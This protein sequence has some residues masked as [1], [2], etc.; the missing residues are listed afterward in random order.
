M[1]VLFVILLMP[2][3]LMAKSPS[4]GD[5]YKEYQLKNGQSLTN[6]YIRGIGNGKIILDSEQGRQVVPINDFADGVVI[7]ASPAEKKPTPIAANEIII[8]GA[9]GLKL[10]DTVSDPMSDSEFFNFFKPTE[11]LEW[12]SLYEYSCTPVSRKIYEIKASGYC[13][14]EDLDIIRVLINEKYKRELQLGKDIND[15]PAYGLQIHQR[16]II[17]SMNVSDNQGM[18]KITL[19]YTDMDL[20]SLANDEREE[21]LRIKAGNMK[22]IKERL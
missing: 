3:A 8:E 4:I 11:T 18:L 12:F 9:F 13:K 5:S 20:L 10:G 15:L 6:V 1:K 2:I 22:G 21:L 7:N 14:I 19:E 17:L 16:H